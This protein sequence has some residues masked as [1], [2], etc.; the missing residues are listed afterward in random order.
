MRAPGAKQERQGPGCKDLDPDLDLWIFFTGLELPWPAD[1]RARGHAGADE[2]WV[3]ATV[4]DPTGPA[5]RVGKR[6]EKGRL[7]PRGFELGT[8][9]ARTRKR[10]H[11]AKLVLVM[12]FRRNPISRIKTTL[13]EFSI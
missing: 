12:G 6:E 13:T 5:V 11:W 4:T 3:A 2:A 9:G 1:A 10:S 8:F 7:A